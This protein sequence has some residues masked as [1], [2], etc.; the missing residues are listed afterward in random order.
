MFILPYHWYGRDQ[1]SREGKPILVGSNIE[2]CA[3]VRQKLRRV[4]D[5]SE[6]RF[7][8]VAGCRFG[9]VHVLTIHYRLQS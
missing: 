4:L 1:C 8:Y 6:Q 5:T 9:R 2:G 3:G 7:R